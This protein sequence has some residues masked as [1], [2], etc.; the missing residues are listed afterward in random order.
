ME[1]GKNRAFGLPDEGQGN[2]LVSFSKAFKKNMDF[3][4]T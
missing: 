2:L 4:Y 3:S 1:N